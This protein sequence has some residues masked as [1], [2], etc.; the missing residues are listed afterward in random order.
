MSGKCPE[1]QVL[2]F[3]QSDEAKKMFDEK[4][5]GGATD[6]INQVFIN[7][8]LENITKTLH[9]INTCDEQCLEDRY[10]K[11][12]KNLW[13]KSNLNLEFAE[14]K[15]IISARNYLTGKKNPIDINFLNSDSSWV[16]WRDSEIAA[17]WQE[18]SK[19]IN[20]SAKTV[21]KTYRILYDTYQ[22]EQ[23]MLDQITKMFLN[24]D[25]PALCEYTV[26]PDICLPLV[27]P[28]KALD[29]MILFNEYHMNKSKL[30]FDKTYVPS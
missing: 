1:D 5:K 12:L 21:N 22:Q 23:N 14:V 20:K 27:G 26:E 9:E 24:Y 25:G 13:D 3:K 6:L 17:E 10:K 30:N 16:N 15:A 19:D 7:T 29:D 8:E 4:F 11:N 2:D 28:G 18:F